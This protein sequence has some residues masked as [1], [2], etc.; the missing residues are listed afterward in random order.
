MSVH[1]KNEHIRQ[2]VLSDFTKRRPYSTTIKHNRT[3]STFEIAEY[4][5]QQGTVAVIRNLNVRPGAESSIH[6]LIQDIGV[7]L[8]TKLQ[9]PLHMEYTCSGLDVLASVVNLV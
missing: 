9:M 3:G 4:A 6:R 1:G 8:L 5:S 2:R 7:D